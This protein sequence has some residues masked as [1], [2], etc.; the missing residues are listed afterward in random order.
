M[1]EFSACVTCIHRRI[2]GNSPFG[3]SYC[4]KLDQKIDDFCIVNKMVLKGCPMAIAKIRPNASHNR[5]G[6]LSASELM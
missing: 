2:I 4:N 3:H 5:R 6:A 1:V